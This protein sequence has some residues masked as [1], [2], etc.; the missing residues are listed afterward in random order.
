MELKSE[1][2]SISKIRDGLFIGDNRAGTNLDLLM[3]FKISH[4]INATGIPLPYSFESLGIKYLTINWT[5]NPPE[6]TVIINDDLI[7]NII[8]FIDESNANGEGLL[9]F[10]GTG[11]NRICVVI[12]LYLMS[13]YNWSLKNCL[14]Y[15]RK[16]KH[17]V[18]IN[19]FYMNQLELYEKELISKN[20]FFN[21]PSN[22]NSDKIKDRDELVMRNTYMNEVNKNKNI[23]ENKTDTNNTYKIVRK[24][25]WGDNKK[26]AR[27]MAQPGLIHYNVDKDLF[28]KTNIEDITEHLHMKPLRSCIKNNT[29]TSTTA[30]IN[31]IKNKALSTNR[32]KKTKIYLAADVHTVNNSNKDCAV[33]LNNLNSI[34]E[35]KQNGFF[36][37]QGRSKDTEIIRE[38][39][40]IDGEKM[41]IFEDIT[42]TDKN[43]DVINNLI[44]MK[45]NK[46][47]DKE[48]REKTEK[49]KNKM[50]AKDRIII[51]SNKRESN[52]NER[53]KPKED[54]PID[55]KH[56]INN[57]NI[58]KNMDNSDSE[59][60]IKLNIINM[61]KNKEKEKE[62]DKNEKN[63]KRSES[64]DKKELKKTMKEYGFNIVNVE[65][66]NKDTTI[67]NFNTDIKPILENL[68]KIDPNLETLN[69]YLKSKK[70]N[71]YLN[72]SDT[73][74]KNNLDKAKK[75]SINSNPKND[76][77]SANNNINAKKDNDKGNSNSI[78][79]VP[80]NLNK[81]NPNK[82]TKS[83]TKDDKNNNNKLYL[84]N[85]NL[86]IENANTININNNIINNNNNNKNNKGF[87][88]KLNNFFTD[89]YGNYPQGFN[90]KK[91]RN[92][93]S[94][95]TG[96]QKNFNN[97][98]NQ[99]FL[100]PNVNYYLANVPHSNKNKE[101]KGN[102]IIPNIN[103]NYNNI[104]INN[105]NHNN[106]INH[107]THSQKSSKNKSN[108]DMKKNSQTKIFMRP[109]ININKNNI[110]NAINANK[111][112]LI[113]SIT[114]TNHMNGFN[115][116]ESKYN[117]I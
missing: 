79:L 83:K 10:S 9:G 76:T 16:K 63:E 58:L 74:T 6:N 4:I 41:N 42:L 21:S 24:V 3:Q 69:K 15:V 111:N 13:K 34:K 64:E 46:D 56:I 113:T 66:K 91:K 18:D 17:D 82:K 61:N 71:S 103:Y 95:R 59:D 114:N 90:N 2:I 8:K 98:N 73:F 96:Y 65:K 55:D 92:T 44:Q 32:R 89:E 39:K 22:W 20:N 50:Y 31:S 97:Y 35:E 23:S 86:N 88:R 93:Y 27:Q 26:Y 11:K 77:I 19:N 107:S 85:L 109:T 116:K 104:N 7:L 52:N 78:N 40:V 105:Y 115:R 49:T 54:T 102:T 36:L 43:D 108:K 72:F 80:I 101:K 33:D 1:V 51:D 117:T 47:K 60:E 106:R 68:L 57:L 29:Y 25:E 62:K 110:N 112:F 67:T 99:Q 30:N 94:A 12:I 87:N 28:L 5:E 100:S 70:K 53:S 38:N 48:N 75:N 84:F 14:E 37:T 81:T 45:G